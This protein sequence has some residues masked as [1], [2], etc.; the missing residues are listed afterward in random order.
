MKGLIAFLMGVVTIFLAGCSP[1]IVESSPTQTN[2]PT[3]TSTPTFTLTATPTWTPTLTPAP[4]LTPIP[5]LTPTPTVVPTPLPGTMYYEWMRP[6]VLAVYAGN[7]KLCQSDYFCPGEAQGPNAGAS[8]ELGRWNPNNPDSQF[9]YAGQADVDPNGPRDLTI[10]FPGEKT[11]QDV[12]LL[13]NMLAVDYIAG[14]LPDGSEVPFNYTYD[15]KGVLVPGSNFMETWMPGGNLNPI[16][17]QSHTRT[18]LRACG[19]AGTEPDGNYSPV[20]GGIL[21]RM[22]KSPYRV[23]QSNPDELWGP[24]GNDVYNFIGIRVVYDNMNNVPA[25]KICH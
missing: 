14:I 23:L 17:S 19:I 10:M 15:P 16:S 8:F 4:T 20:N 22:P 3:R 21:F 18:E 9:V 2:T 1:S 13:F 11:Y 6:N 7:V 5:T 24:R 12:V 25:E